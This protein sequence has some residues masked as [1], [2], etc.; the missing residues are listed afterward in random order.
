MKKIKQI[1]EVTT[2]KLA[3]KMKQLVEKLPFQSKNLLKNESGSRK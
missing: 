3:L 1:R 2:I